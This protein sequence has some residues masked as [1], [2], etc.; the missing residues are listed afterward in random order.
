MNK[1][2]KLS[3]GLVAVVV[4]VATF[5]A[6]VFEGQ[7]DVTIDTGPVMTMAG[8]VVLAIASIWAVKKVIALGNKS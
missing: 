7:G 2:K 4:P 1:L 6:E 8:L 5:A 3:L